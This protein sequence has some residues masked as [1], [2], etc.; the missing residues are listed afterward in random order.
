MTVV[1]GPRE[2]DNVRQATSVCL[3]PHQDP[4]KGSLPAVVLQQFHTHTRTAPHTYKKGTP[5]VR[6]TYKTHARIRGQKHRSHVQDAC[7][8]Q[9]K[10]RR[11]NMRRL[12]AR[13]QPKSYCNSD[14]GGFKRSSRL[15]PRF[16]CIAA[17]CC[18]VLC[19]AVLCCAVL[20][21]V[22]L[23]CTRNT[24][25]CPVLYFVLH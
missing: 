16:G 21:F 25:A 7:R 23:C 8:H 2:Y 18:A 20:N 6:D 17:L 14:P 13:A 11:N 22:V 15:L 1:A 4:N 5:R 10:E 9:E 24:A 3:S 19:C 12:R